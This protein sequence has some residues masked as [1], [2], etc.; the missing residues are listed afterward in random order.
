MTYDLSGKVAVIT[1]ASGNVGGGVVR[2]FAD[3]GAR[4]ALVDVHAERIAGRIEELG[5]DT[6]R[7]KG[8]P[9]NLSTAEA[10]DNL[11]NHIIDHFGQIDSV[12]HT[13]GG[14]AM[15]DPVHAGNLDV[16]DHMMNLNARI[17][18][19]VCGKFASY[20]VDTATPGSITAM[21][22]RSGQKGSKNQA[23]YTAS[24]AAATRII[25]SMALELRDH[26]IR[27]NGVSPSTIDTPPNRDSMPNADFDKWVTPDEVGNLMVF[28]ASDAA[29]AIY[30]ANIEISGRS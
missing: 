7:F 27:V 9:A 13:V 6:E 20:M 25:E 1:G 23:A 11:I 30:G 28:L 18:Y 17:L 29:S 22:A 4:I 10:V 2:A 5:G 26:K 24:K 8:F 21:L 14:F 16:F 15:G 12:V 19:L 3:A